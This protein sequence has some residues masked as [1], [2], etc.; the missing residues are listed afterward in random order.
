MVKK[1]RDGNK[2]CDCNRLLVYLADALLNTI[3]TG[4]GGGGGRIL[5]AATFNLIPFL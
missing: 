4:G 2:N 3:W 1:T 5:P